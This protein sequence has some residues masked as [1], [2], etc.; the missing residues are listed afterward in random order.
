MCGL[1]ATNWVLGFGF[2]VLGLGLAR[3]RELFGLSL[4]GDLLAWPKLWPWLNLSHG[5][6]GAAVGLGALA[7][8]G[9]FGHRSHFWGISGK[10]KIETWPKNQDR[11]IFQPWFLVLGSWFLALGSWLW[12]LALGFILAL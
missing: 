12:L 8:W 7:H 3:A 2:W 1:C 4:G 11:I 9:G 10:V 6:W 5:C